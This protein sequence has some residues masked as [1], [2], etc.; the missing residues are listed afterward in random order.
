MFK[1]PSKPEKKTPDK[2]PKAKSPTR[3]GLAGKFIMSCNGEMT[4]DELC[5]GADSLFTASGGSSNVKES[6]YA[7]RTALQV[8]EAIEVVTMK[9][10]VVTVR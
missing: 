3:T 2:T 4:M 1:Q 10:G 6:R 9:D 8:L 5:E 7:V